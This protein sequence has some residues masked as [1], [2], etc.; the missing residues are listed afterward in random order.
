MDR[1]IHVEIEADT[2]EQAL[3]Q[4]E[5]AYNKQYPDAPPFFADPMFPH[6]LLKGPPAVSGQTGK[7]VLKKEDTLREVVL[8]LLDEMQ[9][10]ALRYG[11]ADVHIGDRHFFDFVV[12][13]YDAPILSESLP[14]GEDYAKL[15]QSSQQRLDGYLA[16]RAERAAASADKAPAGET[17]P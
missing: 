15:R 13:R 7:F 2:L 14:E 1:P 9:D 10:P 3:E 5:A 11:L 8:A 16:T 4:V 6:L 17:K 12:K